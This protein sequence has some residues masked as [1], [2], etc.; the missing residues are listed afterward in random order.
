MAKIKQKK[1]KGGFEGISYNAG[2]PSGSLTDLAEDIAGTI[3]YTINSV[4]NSIGVTT[5]LISL[6]SDMGTAFTEKNAPNPDQVDVTN[7]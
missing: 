3:I 6:P 4:I 7:F 1:Q 5:D 2:G